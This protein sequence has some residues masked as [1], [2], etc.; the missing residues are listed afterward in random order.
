MLEGMEII[1]QFLHHHQQHPEGEKE[2]Q[3]FSQVHHKTFPPP[4]VLQN[5][6]N[7]RAS[8]ESIQK[9]LFKLSSM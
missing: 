6:F 8:E 5:I 9:S 2:V 4:L 1:F 7:Q 3:L